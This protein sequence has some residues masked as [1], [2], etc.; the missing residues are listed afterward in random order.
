MSY[1]LKIHAYEVMGKIHYAVSYRT[2]EEGVSVNPRWR[3][4]L[5]GDM[6]MRDVADIEVWARATVKELCQG[7]ERALNAR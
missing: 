4:L 1:E 7:L 2:Q 5:N 6:E 3:V